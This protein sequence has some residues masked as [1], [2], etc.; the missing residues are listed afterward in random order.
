V[1]IWVSRPRNL[2]ANS[3]DKGKQWPAGRQLEVGKPIHAVALKPLPQSPCLLSPSRAQARKSIQQNIPIPGGVPLPQQH[4]SR[5]GTENSAT[6]HGLGSGVGDDPRQMPMQA[7]LVQQPSTP[8]VP[9]SANAEVFASPLK[10]TN[11]GAVPLAQHYQSQQGAGNSA[12]LPGLCMRSGVGDGL[13]HM[14]MQAAPRQPPSSSCLHSPGT[15]QLFTSNP[16]NISFPGD[17]PL[18][19]QYHSQHGAANSAS[20]PGHWLGSGVGGGSPRR[21]PMQPS[22]TQPASLSCL[23]SRAIASAFAQVLNNVPQN[24]PVPGAVP[25][26]QHYYSQQGA[27]SNPFSLLGLGTGLDYSSMQMHMPVVHMPMQIA[28]PVATIGQGFGASVVGEGVPGLLWQGQPVGLPGQ[29]RPF[30]PLGGR[31]AGRF[32]GEGAPP[33]GEAG[34]EEE[35]QE[36]QDQRSWY[37]RWTVGE[38]TYFLDCVEAKGERTWKQFANDFCLNRAPWTLSRKWTQLKRAAREAQT[39]PH[40]PLRQGLTRDLVTRVRKLDPDPDVPGPPALQ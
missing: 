36:P 31:P 23:S 22:P 30:G 1:Q 40:L 13:R 2:T 19:H 6:R 28:G 16:Q 35:A 34:G 29:G 3:K 5:Q 17:L 26:P 38:T 18:S 39:H 21:T 24:I 11:P 14:L 15:A 8:C 20:L 4:Y 37:S 33:Q 32:G 25:L 7:Y 27:S 9:S 12:S 10:N